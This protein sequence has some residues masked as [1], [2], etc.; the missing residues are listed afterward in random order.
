VFDG[1]NIGPVVNNTMN[2]AT[3]GLVLMNNGIIGQQGS[4]VI[5]NY[6]PQG[7]ASD[8]KW[9]G[10]FANSQTLVDGTSCSTNSKLYVQQTFPYTPTVN[11]GSATCVYGVSTF[12]IFFLSGSPLAFDCSSAPG[13][14]ADDDGDN[15]KARVQLM[16]KTALDSV[17]MGEY[18]TEA[19]WTTQKAVY[20]MLKQDS[21]IMDSSAVLKEFYEASDSTNIGKVTDTGILLT[22]TN[23]DSAATVNQTISPQL[24]IEQNYKELDNIYISLMDG[25]PVDSVQRE[26]LETIANQCPQ[27]G[28]LP[29]YRARVLLNVLNDN[30][31][32]WDDYCASSARTS[33]PDQFNTNINANGTV[34]LFPNPNDGN[35]TLFNNLPPEQ[36]G[37]FVIYDVLGNTIAKTVLEKGVNQKQIDLTAVAPG[38]YY[39]R[40]TVN[41]IVIKNDK[42]IIAK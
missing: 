29:V 30:V 15:D 6:Y 5:P 21:A 34:I 11:V 33:N 39:Y 24:Q 4:P 36:Q 22:E 20:E 8:N 28:G 16:E 42:I 35:M 41:G 25:S 26:I 19:T 2:A 7:V 40:I 14:A 23:T 12:S 9:I 13:I 1:L 31:G 17:A 38:V 3:D 37:E 32:Y 27:Q 18:A 10:P